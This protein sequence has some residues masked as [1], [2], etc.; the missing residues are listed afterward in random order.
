LGG[1]VRGCITGHINVFYH[2]TT[3]S[4]TRKYANFNN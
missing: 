4:A 3:L 1:L 2:K